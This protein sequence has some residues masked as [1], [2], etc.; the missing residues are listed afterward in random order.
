MYV[1]IDFAH[2]LKGREQR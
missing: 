1:D 2:M